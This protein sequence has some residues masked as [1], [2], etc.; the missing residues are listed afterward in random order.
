MSSVI[1][2]ATGYEF[3]GLSTTGK[4]LVN[5]FQRSNPELCLPTS[6]PA[7]RFIRLG[8]PEQNMRL[9]KLIAEVRSQDPEP[10]QPPPPKMRRRIG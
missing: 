5:E 4:R 9:G 1:K 10:T 3:T 7:Y 8:T 6:D 2:T